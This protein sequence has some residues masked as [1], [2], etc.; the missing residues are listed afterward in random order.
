MALHA[1]SSSTLGRCSFGRYQYG[2]RTH[3]FVPSGIVFNTLCF[4]HCCR[5]NSSIMPNSSNRMSLLISA[6]L[7]SA[8]VVVVVAIAQRFKVNYSLG[9]AKCPAAGC[10]S[11]RHRGWF[12]I[13]SCSAMSPVVCLVL[14]LVLLSAMRNS[15]AVQWP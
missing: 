8:S 2:R 12:E 9:L 15:I 14:L 1:Y 7:W 11:I 4:C 6:F 5:R 10:R 13:L 3:F